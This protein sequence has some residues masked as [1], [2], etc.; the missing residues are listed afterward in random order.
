MYPLEH[1][2]PYGEVTVLDADFSVDPNGT[3]IANELLYTGRR[4]DP[5]THLQLNRNRFYH[6]PLGRW[7]NR[8]PIVYRGGMNRYDYVGTRPTFYT[9]PTGL[10]ALTNCAKVYDDCMKPVMDKFEK[11]LKRADQGFGVRSM[12]LIIQIA[13]EA[14]CAMLQ[15]SCE[16]TQEFL[17]EIIPDFS[18]D[19]LRDP[20]R[21]NC[22]RF[23]ENLT[24]PPFE[25]PAPEPIRPIIIPIDPC[26]FPFF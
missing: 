25:M 14:G 16:E 11:C 2:P 24:I 17:R 9:D 8:D 6:A 4:R 21:F 1:R 7:V 22:F 19:P 15:A 3:D 18:Q 26:C 13:G 12:C 23:D 10:Y 5:E 20:G